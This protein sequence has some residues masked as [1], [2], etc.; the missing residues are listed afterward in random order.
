MLWSLAAAT[1][2]DPDTFAN[3]DFHVYHA[4]VDGFGQDDT[5]PP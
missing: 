1:T 2:N 4:S 5:Q 3:Y